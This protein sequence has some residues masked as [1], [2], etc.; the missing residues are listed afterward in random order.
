MQLDGVKTGLAG[1]SGGCE[2]G[3]GILLRNP[4]R[5]DEEVLA[6]KVANIVLKAGDSIRIDTPGGG[7]FGPPSER[8]PDAL[9]ADLRDEII[10]VDDAERYYGA[11][12]TQAAL[13]LHG[14]LSPRA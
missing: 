14:E 10:N 3:R 8:D 1:A 13:R 5:P 6:S 11:S 4:G 12:L 2:G 9:A 7:G